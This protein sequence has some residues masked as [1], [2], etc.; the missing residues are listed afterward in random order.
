MAIRKNHKRYITVQQDDATQDL[1]I[2]IPEELNW[3]EG[4]EVEFTCFQEDKAIIIKNS[5][6]AKQRTE[7]PYNIKQE[8]INNYLYQEDWTW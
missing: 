1:Y 5:R 4:D 3:K 2:Q 7:H 8:E 6:I